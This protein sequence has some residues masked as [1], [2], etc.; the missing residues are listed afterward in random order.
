[1]TGD[2]P[3]LKKTKNKTK[4]IGACVSSLIN[5]FSPSRVAKFNLKV[6]SQR[7]TKIENLVVIIILVALILLPY[8]FYVVLVP[9][10]LS[11][12]W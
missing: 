12:I 5:P 1:M 10:L 8:Y 11:F 4:N 6:G 3:N 9:R 2:R 7:T